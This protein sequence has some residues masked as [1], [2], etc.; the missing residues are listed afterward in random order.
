MTLWTERP[1]PPMLAQTGGAFDSDDYLFE[2]K[3]DGLRTILF[4]NNGKLELQNRNCRVITSGFPEIGTIR[5]DVAAKKVILDGEIVVLDEKGLPDF[6]R[7]QNRFG[8][9][10]PKRIASVSK[11]YP[12]TFAAFDLLHLDGK[13]FLT[14]PLEN[15][16]TQLR[17]IIN[18]GPNLLCTDYIEK[19]GINYYNEALKLGLEG[20]IGKAIHSPYL[21]G[22]RS[23][24]WIKIKGVKTL[25]C[26]V[27]GYTPGE[28]RRGQSFGSLV[29][30]VYNKD[31]ELEHVGNV[32]G[33]FNDQTL[34]SLKPRL[35]GLVREAPVL[36][37]PIEPKVPVTW[38][39]PNLVV[40]TKYMTITSE[41]KLRFPRFGR[42]RNDKKPLDC[43]FE[44]EV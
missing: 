12:T 13:D 4:L 35:E 2:P 34:A 22:I 29:L 24:F 37:K 5:K 19:S 15:R 3:W 11:L 31:N 7:L 33:G 10:E 32:G 25:D 38:V 8:V 27:V 44:Q 30:A 14:M 39:K 28:G 43:R 20:A 9:V 42:L 1:V 40:E 23:G 41:K 6:G 21:P 18:E 26:I 16:K 36:K 17:K